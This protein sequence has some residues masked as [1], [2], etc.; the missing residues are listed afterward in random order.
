[1]TR[2]D[3]ALSVYLN[4]PFDDEYAQLFDAIFFST[5][6]CGF[7]PRGALES[8]SSGIARIMRISTAMA[9]SKYSVHD[10]SRCRGHGGLNL[11]R[12]NMPLELGMAITHA[13]SGVGRHEWFALILRGHDYAHYVSDLVG[14]DLKSHAGTVESMVPPYMAWLLTR[15]EARGDL[16]PRDV[17]TALPMFQLAKKELGERWS[18]EV[19]W[20]HLVR[21]AAEC[22]PV[23]VADLPA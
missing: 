1:V 18:G 22:V 19:P 12:F 6:C 4:V 15:D 13:N 21:I 11:A 16:A 2:P 8:G 10:L 17:L 3:P 20:W 14:F 9:T 5:V 7:I 23:D